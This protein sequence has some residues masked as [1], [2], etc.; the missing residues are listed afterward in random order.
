[1]QNLQPICPP[2]LS[3]RPFRLTVERMM[4]AAPNVLFRAWTQQIDRW[5]AV[6][7]QY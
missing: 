4:R 7:G 5:F 1:M 6:P 3:A 2:D